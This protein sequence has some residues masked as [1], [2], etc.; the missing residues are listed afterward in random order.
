MCDERSAMNARGVRSAAAATQESECARMPSWLFRDRDEAG[1]RLAERLVRF[2]AQHP[3]V[4]ALPRGG[5]PVACPIAEALGVPV[6]VFPVRK[7][8][9][10]GQPELGIGA[11]ALGGTRILSAGAI[12]KLGISADQVEQLIARE[13][14]ELERQ[15]VRFRAGRP[16]PDLHDRTAILVDDGLATGVSARAAMRAVRSMQPARVVL[17]VPVC[18]AETESELQPEADEI[19]CLASLHDFFA[20][21]MWYRD[22][23]Q[24]SDEEVIELV[25]RSRRMATPEEG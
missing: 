24:T 5:V 3:V 14:A 9:A 7:L 10:P 18:A 6:D 22:F 21:G 16:M 19:V 1:R 25:E 13:S 15:N 20:V 4:L 17:A 8:G 23:G 12:Q 2:R 11:L